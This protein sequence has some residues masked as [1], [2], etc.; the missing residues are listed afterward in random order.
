[1]CAQR[2]ETQHDAE[3]HVRRRRH[4]PTGEIWNGRQTLAAEERQARLRSTSRVVTIRRGQVLN[5][6][7]QEHSAADG[8]KDLK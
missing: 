4:T 1:M 3:P 2:A 6:F 5:P 7:A 8:S